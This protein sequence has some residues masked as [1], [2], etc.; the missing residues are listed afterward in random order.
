MTPYKIGFVSLDL[1]FKNLFIGEKLLRADPNC[2]SCS[3][4][5]KSFFFNLKENFIFINWLDPWNTAHCAFIN[6]IDK[7]NKCVYQRQIWYFEETTTEASCSID[8]ISR[9]H[10]FYFPRSCF[11]TKQRRVISA[12]GFLLSLSA[13]SYFRSV[14]KISLTHFKSLSFR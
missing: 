11:D 4:W 8:S 14:T 1:T 13:N 2:T 3:K 12:A 6:K 5:K 7:L 10:L 9:Q